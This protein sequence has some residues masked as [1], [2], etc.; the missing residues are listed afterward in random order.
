MSS[1]VLW[2]RTLQFRGLAL[3]I[4]FALVLPRAGQEI[5]ARRLLL[6]VVKINTAQ[7]WSSQSGKDGWSVCSFF[8][9]F[10]FYEVDV[11]CEI[12]KACHLSNDK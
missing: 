5:S 11:F 4:D 3:K 10:L 7:F 1:A 12:E 2:E 9:H 6:I 8:E